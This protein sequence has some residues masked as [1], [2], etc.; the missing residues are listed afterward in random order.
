MV[1]YVVILSVI[2]DLSLWLYVVCNDINFGQRECLNTFRG[3]QHVG[4]VENGMKA[5]VIIIK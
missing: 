4:V 1:C 3:L 2:L 5:L